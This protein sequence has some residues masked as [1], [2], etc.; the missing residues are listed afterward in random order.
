MKL[1]RQTPG[2]PQRE[3]QATLLLIQ[4][5]FFLWINWWTEHELQCQ[6]SSKG[7]NM[8]TDEMTLCAKSESALKMPRGVIWLAQ[9]KP[10]LDR[11]GPQARLGPF[12]NPT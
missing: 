6:T 2:N 11:L 5:V 1:T 8:D 10:A 7:S 3:C 4:Q 9:Q 12:P